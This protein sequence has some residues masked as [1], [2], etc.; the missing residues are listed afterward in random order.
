[1]ISEACWE[2]DAIDIDDEDSKQ[3]NATP[4]LV[5]E[6]L[7]NPL[8]LKTRNYLMFEF[9]WGLGRTTRREQLLWQIDP[10]A[11]WTK[12]TFGM[13]FES[14]VECLSEKEREEEY[15]SMSSKLESAERERL[16]LLGKGVDVERLDD[17]DLGQVR[18]RTRQQTIELKSQ[19]SVALQEKILLSKST[20]P[21]T[22]PLTQPTIAPHAFKE[23]M[24]NFSS[25]S[26]DH[27]MELLA[28]DKRL[29]IMIGQVFVRS[30]TI[31][32]VVGYE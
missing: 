19:I 24:R 9:P 8:S 28:W 6:Y 29:F 22:V 30:F 11:H 15:A 32:Y 17:R 26:Y 16:N 31:I 27:V 13:T 10:G 12:G 21:V 20:T 2:N 1:M 5:E 18:A 4:G 14:S 7:D 25:Y 3:E 23:H